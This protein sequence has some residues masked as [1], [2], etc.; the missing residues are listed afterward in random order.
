M[1]HDSKRLKTLVAR[2]AETTK[3][4]VFS[5]LNLSPIVFKK[6]KVKHQASPKVVSILAILRP[7][8]SPRSSRKSG[9]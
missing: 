2:L 1:S 6:M 7:E 8:M 3:W 4:L 9:W 5:S